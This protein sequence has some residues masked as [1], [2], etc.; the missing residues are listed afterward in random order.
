MVVPVLMINCHVSE[1][2]KIGPV[3]AQTITMTQQMMKASAWPVAWDTASATWVNHLFSCIVLVRQHPIH[4][5]FALI[6]DPNPDALDHE[7]NRIDNRS[8]SNDGRLGGFHSGRPL[9]GSAMS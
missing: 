6:Q 2:P 1:K 9:V 3:A 4:K 5:R 7:Q 8:N